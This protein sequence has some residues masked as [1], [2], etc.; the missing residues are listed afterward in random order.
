M[1]KELKD[2]LVPVDFEQ[3]SIL[4][5]EYAFEL[6]KLINCNIHLLYVIRKLDFISEA[7]RS[8]DELVKITESAKQ[9]LEELAL[10]YKKESSV[11]FY[12][13]IER[14]KVYEKVAETAES[15]KARIIVLG[16]N[17]CFQTGNKTL[18]SNSMQIISTA[19]CPVFITK[20]KKFELLK[21][22]L[23]PIDLSTEVSKQI[24]SAIAYGKNY[25]AKIHLVSVVIGGILSKKSRIFKK[26]KQIQKTLSDN[27]IVCTSKLY[28]FTSDA[29]P[30]KNVLNYAEEIKA[31][32]LLLMTH[33][34]K[35]NDNYIGAFAHNIMNES[36]IPVISLTACATS[37][38]DNFLTDAIDPFGLFSKTK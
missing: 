36:T 38:S 35:R 27:G 1:K 2:I 23:V 28:D 12:T 15:I 25:D 8:S 9:K 22:I 18:G 24:S 31:D 14:G 20:S 32:S 10:K 13:K 7:L 3:A 17:H 21:N 29:I 33:Q 16:D 26:L 11:N 5:V 19:K 34:E 4:A 6:A 37:E 30:Y